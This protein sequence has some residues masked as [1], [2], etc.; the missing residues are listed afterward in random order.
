MN[1]DLEHDKYVLPD[2]LK[3]QLSI[4][5]NGMGSGDKGYSRI[6]DI[7]GDGYLNYGKAKKFKHELE[8][9]LDGND[10]ENVCGDDMLSFIDNCLGKRRDS[11]VSGKTS[12]MN[13][14]ME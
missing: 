9:E 13:A 5:L 1:Q 2:D 4:N 8:N 14:G 12:R 6:Q 10:Y 3:N 11:V 7:L